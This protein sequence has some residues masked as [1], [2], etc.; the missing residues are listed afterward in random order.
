MKQLTKYTCYF[1][2]ATT[3]I[4]YAKD[5]AW[6]RSS[7]PYCQSNWCHPQTPAGEWTLLS[8]EVIHSSPDPWRTGAVS[9][10]R[11]Y[12]KYRCFFQHHAREKA[13]ERTHFLRIPGSESLP[14]LR[15]GTKWTRIPAHLMR[16]Q[17]NQNICLQ[18]LG[19]STSGTIL[20]L[21][22]YKRELALPWPR[23]YAILLTS[24][25]RAPIQEVICV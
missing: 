10:P 6:M 25:V 21:A 18:S 12:L 17:F 24:G 20:Q 16:T 1:I 19:N 3:R 23:L 7:F 15:G 13:G 11:H 8:A 2:R 22:W 5:L 4:E 14:T 9:L